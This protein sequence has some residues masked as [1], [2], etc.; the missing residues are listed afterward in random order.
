MSLEEV[1]LMPFFFN[2]SPYIPY[3]DAGI[4][5]NEPP[6]VQAI[7][8]KQAF[9]K[10]NKVTIYYSHNILDEPFSFVLISK[11]SFSVSNN[12]Y[13]IATCSAPGLYCL[14]SCAQ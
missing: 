10:I 2:Y 13:S 12:L 4:V 1:K 7:Q 14:L 5:A 9:K 3:H 8:N 6:V 11:V